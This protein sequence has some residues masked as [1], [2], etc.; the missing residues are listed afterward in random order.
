MDFITYYKQWWLA[1]NQIKR[2]LPKWSFLL[3]YTVGPLFNIPTKF[4]ISPPFLRPFLTKVKIKEKIATSDEPVDP[5][6]FKEFCDIWYDGSAELPPSLKKIK[7]SFAGI[8]DSKVW[9]EMFY[10]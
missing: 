10:F 6:A 1:R 2:R 5:K 4:L 7:L 3:G 8:K 9:F